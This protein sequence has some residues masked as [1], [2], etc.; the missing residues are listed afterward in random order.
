MF[1]EPPQSLA[2]AVRD[3]EHL[4][5]C[6]HSR[7][8]C[9]P[10]PGQSCGGQHQNRP[11]RSFLL[12]LDGACGTG[13]SPRAKLRQVWAMWEPSFTPYAHFSSIPAE[14]PSL[15][16]WTHLGQLLSS[17]GCWFS[18]GFKQVFRTAEGRVWPR[19][20]AASKNI[21]RS[22]CVS[23]EGRK[24]SNHKSDSL[25]CL[26][27]TNLSSSRTKPFLFIQ[28]SG[29]FCCFNGFTNWICC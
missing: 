28:Q 7:A 4:D 5:H 6:Q 18:S 11:E 12:E 10:C 26:A 13:S 25:P 19:E 16:A 3:T 24:D 15:A 27:E 2:V 1:W 23:R 14:P 8:I 21:Y 22:C 29:L 9:V 17:F 20:A